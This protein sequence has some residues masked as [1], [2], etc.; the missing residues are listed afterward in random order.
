MAIDIQSY[1]KHNT[2]LPIFCKDAGLVQSHYSL[3]PPPLPDNQLSKRLVNSIYVW[4]KVSKI[5]CNSFVRISSWVEA[6]NCFPSQRKKHKSGVC[7][8]SCQSCST[9]RP[10]E[11][12]SLLRV[13]HSIC[14]ALLIKERGHCK[15]TLGKSQDHTRQGGRSDCYGSCGCGVTEDIQIWKIML[16]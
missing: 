10:V 14:S 5:K 1:H 8:L 3:S 2:F 11:H 4:W 6:W 9:H 13:R 7:C 15:E 16:C 12:R